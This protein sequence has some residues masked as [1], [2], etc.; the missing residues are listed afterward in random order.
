M[1]Q[2]GVIKVDCENVVIGPQPAPGMPPG[3]YVKIKIADRGVG[4]PREHL[5]K[6]FDPYFTTKQKGSGLGLAASYSIMKKH[7][8]DITA[9][10]VIGLGTTLVLYLPAA[11]GE[12]VNPSG[13]KPA[14]LASGSGRV[15]IMDDEEIIRDAARRIL[16]TAGY[17]VEVTADG[18]E[19]IDLYRKA[20]ETGKPFGV[21]IMDLT[22]PGGIG[23]KD[24]IKR[25][26]EID[27][28]VR[29]IVSSGYSHDPIM[30]NYRDYGFMGVIAKPYKI[31]EMSEIV[32]KVLTADPSRGKG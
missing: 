19:A 25:L 31:R 6:I 1:P 14:G 12:E 10:S 9:E 24:A 17:E 30:A 23:G 32:R 26:L 22:V 21:V 27:P 5:A 29:A 28:A 18:S 20:R 2:G 4:I 8:G 16:Q 11:R 15:L 13:S 3:E 7:G